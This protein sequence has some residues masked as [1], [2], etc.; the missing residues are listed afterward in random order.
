MT[1]FLSYCFRYEYFAIAL[2]L[3]GV[4]FLLRLLRR[5]REK[6]KA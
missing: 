1:T 4:L 2:A 5:V 3:L 6:Q